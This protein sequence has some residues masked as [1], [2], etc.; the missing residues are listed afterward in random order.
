MGKAFG[1]GDENGGGAHTDSSECAVAGNGDRG[2]GVELHDALHLSLDLTD[3][4]AVDQ[5]RRCP[6]VRHHDGY[7]RARSSGACE[8][9]VVNAQWGGNLMKYGVGAAWEITGVVGAVTGTGGAATG[10][11][12][13]V[14]RATGTRAMIMPAMTI[15]AGGSRLTMFFIRDS[16]TPMRLLLTKCDDALQFDVMANYSGPGELEPARNK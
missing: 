4:F 12:G 9:P 13:A 2:R 14:T 5:M 6:A 15:G 8:E 3:K 1:V 16:M 10:V 11:G 7:Q